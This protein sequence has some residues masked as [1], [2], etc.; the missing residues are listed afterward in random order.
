MF[1]VPIWLWIVGLIAAVGVTA[2]VATN[3]IQQK[4]VNPPR[5]NTTANQVVPLT[6][7]TVNTVTPKVVVPKTT[8]TGG[9]SQQIVPNSSGNNNSVPWAQGPSDQ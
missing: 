6:N 5:T 1:I 3:A 2:T 7:T 8:S 4:K 9:V